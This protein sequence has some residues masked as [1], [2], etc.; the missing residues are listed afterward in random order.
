MYWSRISSKSSSP[1]HTRSGSR[2][3]AAALP[4]LRDLQLQ[5]AH[6][7]APRPGSVAVAVGDPLA[8]RSP[9]LAPG[10]GGYLGLHHCL[11][12]HTQPLAQEVEVL[13]SGASLRNSSNTSILSLAIA[14]TSFIFVVDEGDALAFVLP[15]P[16]VSYTISWD[17]T[18]SRS[19]IERESAVAW[20]PPLDSSRPV[21]LEKE[22]PTGE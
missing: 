22:K 20:K 8:L 18:P 13:A 4:H 19:R 1:P 7:R 21:L 17:T 2:G 5:G 15:G 3:V 10:L 11:N 14:L 12:Q 16:P 9:K 6:P